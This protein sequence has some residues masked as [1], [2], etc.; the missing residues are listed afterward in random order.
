MRIT[1]ATV[2]ID[3]TR[4]FCCW[5]PK[6][7]T[8]KGR[9]VD[10]FSLLVSFPQG[11]IPLLA[12]AEGS[13]D[14]LQRVKQYVT[15]CPMLD[16]E[17]RLNWTKLLSE[18]IPRSDNLNDYCVQSEV[19][20]RSFG[21]PL[22]E[23]LL[24]PRVRRVPSCLA[25]QVVQDTENLEQYLALAALAMPSV[26]NRFESNPPHPRFQLNNAAVIQH[27]RE[28]FVAKVDAAFRVYLDGYTQQM[29]RTLIMRMVSLDGRE[30]YNRGGLKP[31]QVKNVIEWTTEFVMAFHRPFLPET[32]YLMN[33][34]LER[35]Y[36]SE[37]DKDK[38]LY[39]LTPE[40]AVTK[41]VLRQK[42]VCP[43]FINIIAALFQK[44][45]AA[46]APSH[47]S[48]NNLMVGYAPYA[49][50]MFCGASIFLSDVI[51]DHS[52]YGFAV[53]V[54]LLVEGLWSFVVWYK[55]LA[56]YVLVCPFIIRDEAT[57]LLSIKTRLDAAF[58]VVEQECVM[59]NVQ[60]AGV[61]R[62]DVV[63]PDACRT[64]LRQ[65]MSA[66]DANAH[67]MELSVIHLY[68]SMYYIIFGCP[69]VYDLRIMNPQPAVAL[70][71]YA[72]HGSLIL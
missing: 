44:R 45:N 32:A 16:Q 12:F 69:L 14:K 22:D 48:I 67:V 11:P 33:S 65:T 24:G 18:I 28:S 70:K 17:H 21:C 54:P 68:V 27:A 43:V 29:L 60:F 26:H 10:G 20:I 1:G 34:I 15:T 42:M 3:F 61:P 6:K 4:V 40:L 59:Y 38:V 41:R 36:D 53:F 7:D 46:I 5:Y 19:V 72:F 50:S 13:V 9:M 58:G 71:Y 30:R 51:V 35:P 39:V 2:G 63:D 62:N 57:A 47:S 64:I 8:L 25:P 66:V 55:V 37:E 52:E 23:Y 56:K 49:Q 31:T